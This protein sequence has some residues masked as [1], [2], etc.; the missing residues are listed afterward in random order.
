MIAFTK[1]LLK[2]NVSCFS[3]MRVGC[4]L[5]V[6][7]SYAPYSSSVL[8]IDPVIH[9]YLFFSQDWDSSS[10]LSGHALSSTASILVSNNLFLRL[11][12]HRLATFLRQL[13]RCLRF[14][15]PALR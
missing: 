2:I 12:R 3:G 8:Q 15:S 10:F 11:V 6:I 4:L 14:S 9:C 5:F 7:Q 1:P 13:L